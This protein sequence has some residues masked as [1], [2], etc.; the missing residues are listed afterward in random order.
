MCMCAECVRECVCACVCVCVF[1]VCGA[2]VSDE[3]SVQFVS[4]YVTFVCARRRVFRSVY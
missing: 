1:V 4:P 2:C 3:F